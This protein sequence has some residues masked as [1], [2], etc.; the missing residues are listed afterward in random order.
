MQNEPLVHY[1]SQKEQ[2]PSPYSRSRSSARP[3][4]RAPL[5]SIHTKRVPHGATRTAWHRAALQCH[6]VDTVQR[7]RYGG[8][9]CPRVSMR[10][11]RT[12]RRCSSV[13]T[14]RSRLRS[15]HNEGVLL[16]SNRRALATTCLLVFCVVGDTAASMAG[17]FFTLFGGGHDLVQC[18]C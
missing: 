13:S 4:M 11:G 12:P 14:V 1:V 9:C 3:T 8:G 2:T 15:A 6:P 17:L 16:A 10:L 5:A 18:L 7:G